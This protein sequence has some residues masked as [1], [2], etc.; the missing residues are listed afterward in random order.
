MSK[1]H[2]DHIIQIDPTLGMMVRMQREFQCDLLGVA[3]VN[4]PDGQKMGYLREQ[5]LALIAEV[6]EALSETGWKSWASSNHV[7]TEAYKRELVDVW[8]FFMN[9]MLVVDMQPSEL[10]SMYL[11]KNLVNRARQAEGYD[12]VSTKCPQCH[13]AYDDIAVNCTPALPDQGVLKFSPYCEM[14]K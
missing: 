14:S 8:H 10:F 1:I 12:G 6:H 9:L 3:P 7:N 2:A 13:R 4:L 5:A 11:E